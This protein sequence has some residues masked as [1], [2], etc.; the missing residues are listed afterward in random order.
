M[1]IDKLRMVTGHPVHPSFIHT[2]NQALGEKHPYKKQLIVTIQEEKKPTFFTETNGLRVHPLCKATVTTTTGC[3]RDPFY[4]AMNFQATPGAPTNVNILDLNPNKLSQGLFSLMGI[5]REI[6][7]SEVCLQTSRKPGDSECPLGFRI[8]RIDLNADVQLP[9]DFLA[10]TIRVAGK[11]KVVNFALE[12][13]C[14]RGIQTF[15]IGC[16]PARLRV[17]DKRRELETIG[18]DLSACPPVLSRIEWELRH[19][20][21]PIRGLE[22]IELL[23]DYHPFRSLRIYE[24]PEL[25]DFE[26]D[27]KP[28]IRRFA[29]SRMAAELGAHEAARILSCERPFKREYEPVLLE[30][31]EIRDELAASYQQGIA[32]FLE[33]RPNL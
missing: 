2:L 11:R 1:G 32:N 33:N 24:A 18:A 28:S 29:F 4:L 8:S 3:G 14:N 12:A 20:R 30:H 6:W 15:Y 16:S 5:I 10:R 17:Y 9:I 25:F 27:L 21:C 31:S 26:N 19:H 23:R 7:G 13:H 22:Q